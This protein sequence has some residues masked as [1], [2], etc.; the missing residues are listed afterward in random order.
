VVSSLR[1]V[2][3]AIEAVV[4]VAVVLTVVLL[5][6]NDPAS[7]PPLPAEAATADPG[8]DAAAVYGRSCAGC[9]GGDGSGGIGPGLSGGRVVSAFPD[10]AAQTAVVA[11]GRGGMPGFAGRLTDAE[12]AAVVEYTR[13]ALAGG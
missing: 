11:E 8:I 3:T 13:V 2:A 9:H 7:P 10:P 1:K 12:I 5:F 6:V 4:L